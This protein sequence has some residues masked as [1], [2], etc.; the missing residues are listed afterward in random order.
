M[1]GIM[2]FLG[3]AGCY[4]RF[5]P[6]FAEVAYPVT[7][8]L[9]SK[10]TFQWTKACQAA[11]ETLDSILATPLDLHSPDLQKQ[12]IL[13]VDTSDVGAGAVSLQEGQECGVLQ[14]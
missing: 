6:R 10:K 2:R 13:H 4:R 3:M 11:F 5:C 14:P 8:L 1:K 12:F 7:D 9:N